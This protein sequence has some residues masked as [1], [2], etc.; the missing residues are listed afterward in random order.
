MGCLVWGFVAG[1][2]YYDWLVA[3]IGW[4][5][6]AIWGWWGA[7]IV[8]VSLVYL[9]W[10]FVELVGCY[11]VWFVVCGWGLIVMVGCCLLVCV[12]YG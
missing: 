12:W 5:G 8:L 1:V 10:V 2:V 3:L 9:G 11:L 7:V 6:L 4:D